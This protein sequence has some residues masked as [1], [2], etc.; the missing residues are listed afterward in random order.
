M[1]VMGV[2]MA[3]VWTRDIIR[4]DQL[5]ISAGRLR[6]RDPQAGTFLLPHWIAEYGT[7][8]A[9]LAGAIGLLIDADWGRSLAF[10]ALGTLVYT[11]VNSLGWA[12][13]DPTRFPYAVPMAFGAVGSLAAIIGLFIV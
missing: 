4:A 8:A 1:M 11:S 10:V 5:D 6:A 12:L 9:L 2:A 7:A 3:G 13:A